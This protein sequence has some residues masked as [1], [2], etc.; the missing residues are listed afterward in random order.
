MDG[1]RRSAVRGLRR[2]KSGGQLSVGSKRARK[3]EASAKEGRVALADAR[4]LVVVQFQTFLL[5][6]DSACFNTLKRLAFW[7]TFA[8]ARLREAICLPKSSG[9]R[10][11]V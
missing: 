4:Q 2:T 1:D 10:R 7:A 8:W 11:A 9:L 6:S 3:N 5:R